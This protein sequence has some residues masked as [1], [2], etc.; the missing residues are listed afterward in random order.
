M[1]KNFGEQPRE[2]ELPIESDAQVWKRRLGEAKEHSTE[3]Q[4]EVVD[5]QEAKLGVTL[6]RLMQR[7][8]DNPEIVNNLNSLLDALDHQSH[9]GDS[10]E[11]IGPGRQ[12]DLQKFLGE[13]ANALRWTVGGGNRPASLKVDLS[14][15][16]TK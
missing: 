4:N 11:D 9:Y 7:S 8:G 12:D 16:E 10:A 15:W 6:R 14:K 2:E 3:M 5:I 1:A 13:A